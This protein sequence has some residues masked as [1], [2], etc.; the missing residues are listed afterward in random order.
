MKICEWC[1]RPITNPSHGNQRFHR[2]GQGPNGQ[3]CF[4]EHRRNY[5]RL[6]EQQR[7]HKYKSV[8]KE[9]SLGTGFLSQHSHSDFETEEHEILKELRRLRLPSHPKILSRVNSEGR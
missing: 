4:K 5:K 6:K 3:N 1:K 7:Y 8:T 2:E 9:G